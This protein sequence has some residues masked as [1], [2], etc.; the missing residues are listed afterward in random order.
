MPHPPNFDRIARAY[1]WLEYLALGPALART[2]LYFLH[3]AD[4]AARLD[5]C[6][7]ALVL[8]DG[9]GRFLA[10]ILRQNTALQAHAVDASKEM[11]RLLSRR[12]AFAAARRQ[13]HHAD[14]LTFT[15]PTPVDLVVTHFFLDCLT[16]GQLAD[17]I[18]RVVSNLQPSGMWLISEFRIPP[19]PMRVPAL[20]YVALL[21]R[22]FRLLTGL[23]I[24]RLPDHAAALT[25]AGLTLVAQH[26]RLFGVLTSQLWQLPPHP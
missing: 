8:G 16:Q 11:L 4:S 22:T 14:A 10:H 12:T 13:T 25:G 23:Q 1:R 18:P 26:H 21:Y 7:Q 24:A 15:P 2:R 19:G 3:Q 20:L 6:R 5:S 9:D 17:F